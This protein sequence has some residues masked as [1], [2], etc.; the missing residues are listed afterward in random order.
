MYVCLAFYIQT[1]NWHFRW[2]WKGEKWSILK[3]SLCLIDGSFRSAGCTPNITCRK[4]KKN[5]ISN[6]SGF[7]FKQGNLWLWYLIDIQ[8]SNVNVLM[9]FSVWHLPISPLTFIFSLQS[10]Y[11]TWMYANGIQNT[12]TLNLTSQLQT[13]FTLSDEEADIYHAQCPSC[14]IFSLPD[15][16]LLILFCC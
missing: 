16:F 2:D 13:N 14:S 11:L 7:S 15:G 4:E 12:C 8:C 3:M 1:V 5:Q 6:S 10:I 9:N